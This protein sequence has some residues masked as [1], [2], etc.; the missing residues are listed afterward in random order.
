[1]LILNHQR[2]VINIG[3]VHQ[4]CIFINRYSVVIKTKTK[5]SNYVITKIAQKLNKSYRYS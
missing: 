5:I 4:S 3:Q 2:V 1:M